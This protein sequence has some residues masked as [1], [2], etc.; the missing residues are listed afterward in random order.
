[1]TSIKELSKKLK[2]IQREIEKF[3]HNCK[4]PNQTIR[5]DEKN[6]PKWY[7]DVCDKFIRMPSQQELQDWIK[8]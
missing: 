3:Q 4:H 1:M 5:F 2:E 7:C 8:R 6:C